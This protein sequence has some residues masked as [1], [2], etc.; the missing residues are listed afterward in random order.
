MTENNLVYVDLYGYCNDS[1]KSYSNRG[2]PCDGGYA[3]V[4][5]DSLTTKK[6]A[7]LL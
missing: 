4:F 2:I 3:F 5:F 1:K 7:I 6:F